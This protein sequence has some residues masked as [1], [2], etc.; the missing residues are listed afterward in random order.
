MP[1][2]RI[3]HQDGDD[4]TDWRLQV[5]DGN[6]EAAR[7]VPY[8]GTYRFTTESRE[9]VSQRKNSMYNCDPAEVVEFYEDKAGVKIDT[10]KMCSW[11]TG[12]RPTANT[13]FRD[14]TFC[15]AQC[16]VKHEHIKAEA[17][18]VERQ[19]ASSEVVE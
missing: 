12:S 9:Y 7:Q 11:P 1:E 16:E 19:E 15:S 14:S 3:I 13:T 6:L 5:R 10:C 18:E 4:H 8:D 2:Q 17:R